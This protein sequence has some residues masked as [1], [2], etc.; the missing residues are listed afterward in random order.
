M[1]VV[2]RLR[3]LF[4]RSSAPA[5]AKPSSLQNRSDYKGTWDRLA[6]SQENAYR[7]VA[8]RDYTN[9][10]A[11]DELGEL[12]VTRLENWVGLYPEDHILEIG[13]GVGRT[14]KLLSPRSAKWTGA[15]ISGN[16]LTYAAQRLA[17]LDNIELVELRRRELRQFE[18]ATFDL[19]YCTVV[20]MH[21]LEWDRYRYVKDMYRVLRPGVRC[22]FD[23]A[24]IASDG[25]WEVFMS[26]Y[27]FPINARPPQI[28]MVSSGD[29]LE[30]YARHAG[31][32]SIQ[33]QRWDGWVAVTARKPD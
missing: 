28:S 13:C 8:S 30:A 4:S 25:G 31:F 18:D 16:M 10:Q 6:D 21:L 23:N 1:S 3:G 33:V 22:Y 7:Y 24:D 19:T 15:D 9:D 32:E 12:T 17:G 20:F 27:K 5:A 26:G 11:M 29:E 14:G 2:S